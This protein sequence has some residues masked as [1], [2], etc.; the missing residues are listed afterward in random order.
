[1]PRAALRPHKQRY[2]WKSEECKLLQKV[3]GDYLSQTTARTLEQG[4]LSVS[5]SRAIQ[6]FA[7]SRSA[8]D[9]SVNCAT[10][11]RT[12]CAIER[13]Y[14]LPRC[15]L[16]GTAGAGSCTYDLLPFQCIITT[17]CTD[18]TDVA[19]LTRRLDF[20][21]IAPR[22]FFSNLLLSSSTRWR[23]GRQKWTTYTET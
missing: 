12:R 3:H 22:I 1:M 21:G 13:R 20:W 18:C 19:H 5:M 16:A 11:G 4:I 15:L 6:R 9:G 7:R 10:I 14:L 2:T 8:I 23:V 17:D